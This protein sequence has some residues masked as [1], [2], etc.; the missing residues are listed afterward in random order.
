MLASHRSTNPLTSP[1]ALAL[2]LIALFFTVTIV[3]AARADDGHKDKC[4]SHEAK[5]YGG[6]KDH[7]MPC[8]PHGDMDDEDDDADNPAP[9]TPVTPPASTTNVDNSDHSVT[10]NYFSSTG[11][12]P[13]TSSS[14]KTLKPCTQKYKHL[15]SVPGLPHPVGMRKK[16]FRCETPAIQRAYE[17]YKRHLR[18]K[19]LRYLRM[20]HELER[21]RRRA[22]AR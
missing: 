16:P 9:P 10:N 20:K 4:K 22:G 3:P 15:I 12:A 13:L 18:A 5:S 6:D 17:R 19:H 1:V 21:L 7:G 11:S 14:S 2:A 8:K